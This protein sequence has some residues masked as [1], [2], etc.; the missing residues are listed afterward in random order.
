[1]YILATE[2][3]RKISREELTHIQKD[4][5]S[6]FGT[7]KKLMDIKEKADKKRKESLMTSSLRNTHYVI[8]FIKIRNFHL[9]NHMLSEFS[10]DSRVFEFEILRNI[11]T[12]YVMMTSSTMKGEMGSNWYP[13][14][15]HQLQR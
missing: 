6:E 5:E 10:G 15:L 11:N 4:I 3:E 14:Q 1:M 8:T 9:P 2:T 7:L 13:S 12:Y